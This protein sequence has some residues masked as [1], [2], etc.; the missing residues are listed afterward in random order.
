MMVALAPSLTVR[1]VRAGLGLSRE[2]MARLLDVSTRTVE[3]WEA[4][5]E[6]PSSRFAL[7]QLASLVR[8]V[9]LGRV[10]YDEPSF[11]RFFVTP[12]PAFDGRS[13]LQLAEIGR[14]DRV[15]GALASLYEGQGL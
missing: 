8:V 2:R 1:S 6:L 12:L 7:D 13:A 10:V 4:R 9:E 14:A 15:V 3:R 11:R 5:D